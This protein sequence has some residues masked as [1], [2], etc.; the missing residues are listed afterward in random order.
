MNAKRILILA[1]A[2]LFVAGLAQ[3]QT[4]SSLSVT[5]GAVASIVINSARTT[6]S[7][8]ATPFASFLGT[9]NFTYKIRTGNTSGTGSIVVA[10]SGPLTGTSSDTIA[11]SNLSYVCTDV[12]PASGT[13]CSSG[14]TASTTATNVASFGAN[15]HSAD[16]G[17]PGNSLAWTL[18]NNPSYVA[19]TYSATATFTISAS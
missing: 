18:V 19:D 16:G 13:A 5:V 10:L 9:T 4:T 1:I 15:N 12:A 7:T 14:V 3:A 6:F 17:T 11:L 8:P 2:L